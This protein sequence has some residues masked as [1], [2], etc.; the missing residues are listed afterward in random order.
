MCTVAKLCEF[1]HSQWQTVAPVFD[2]SQDCIYNQDS[3]FQLHQ[4]KY[5]AVLTP[6]SEG[7]RH[8]FT[9]VKL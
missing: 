7:W 9:P 6:L 5:V 2:C 3:K 1:C 8:F 4:F